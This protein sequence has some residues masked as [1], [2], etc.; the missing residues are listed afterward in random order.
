MFKKKLQELVSEF[1]NSIILLMHDYLLT[2]LDEAKRAL[3]APA[4]PEKIKKTIEPKSA[5]FKKSDAAMR[6]RFTDKQ[7]HRCKE[8]S[9]GP[10]FHFLCAKHREKK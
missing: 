3:D 1:A 9:G 6:C 7:S 2:P 4:S 10:R 5:K 8:R